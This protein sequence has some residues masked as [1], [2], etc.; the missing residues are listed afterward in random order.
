[1]EPPV[2]NT[3]SSLRLASRLLRRSSRYFASSQLLAPLTY[4]HEHTGLPVVLS[5][6]SKAG[7]SAGERD[8]SGYS[9]AALSCSCSSKLAL[10]VDNRNFTFLLVFV[11][12]KSLTTRLRRFQYNCLYRTTYLPTCS[13]QLGSPTRSTR[14]PDCRSLLSVLRLAFGSIRSSNGGKLFSYLASHPPPSYL[15]GWIR[16]S[17]TKNNPTPK[18]SKTENNVVEELSTLIQQQQCNKQLEC[19]SLCILEIRQTESFSEPARLSYSSS[20]FS[21]LSSPVASLLWDLNLPR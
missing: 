3:T 21:H 6:S 8:G 20:S 18:H 9:D 12:V 4:T 13:L 17:Q 7:K 5:I 10:L 19:W 16:E 1:M 2:P 11:V 14:D 15:A